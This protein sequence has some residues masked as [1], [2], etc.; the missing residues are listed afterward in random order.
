VNE[1]EGYSL[2]EDGK[3]IKSHDHTMDAIRYVCSHLQ[4]NG[5]DEIPSFYGYD[6]WM[7]DEINR[8]REKGDID[9]IIKLKESQYEKS[10]S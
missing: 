8:L 5:P 4:A 9:A 2:A 7:K 3:P 10:F 1:I 6:D